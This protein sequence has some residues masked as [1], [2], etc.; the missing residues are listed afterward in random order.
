MS[1]TPTQWGASPTEWEHFTRL[2]LTA[3]LL[4]VVSNP[5][6]VIAG[7]SSLRA[8]GKTPSMYNRA[9]EAVGIPK[10]TTHSSTDRDVKR[11]QANG[12]LGI[13]LQT[14]TVRAIDV[15][16]DDPETADAVAWW[17]ETVLGHELPA[18]CRGDSRKFLLA[19]NMPGEFVK[20]VIHTA[21]GAIEF[22]ATGQQ[23]I[24]CGTHPKGQRY[25]WRGGLPSEIPSVTPAQFEELWSLLAKEFAI[26]PVVTGRG[27]SKRPLLP[28]NSDDIKDP[29]VSFL[30]Q[31]GWVKG[32]QRDGRVD[33]RC[34]WES[35]HT[36][37]SADSATTWFPAGVGGFEQG[38]FRCLHAHCEHRSD[39]EFLEEVGYIADAFE[40]VVTGSAAVDGTPA[41]GEE[42]PMPIFQRSRNGTI[43]STVHN[44][45][46]AAAREDVLGCH[47]AYDHFKGQLVVAE[48]VADLGTAQWRAM[49]DT[50]FTSMRATLERRG[51]ESVGRELIRDVV[52]LVA[53]ERSIDTAVEWLTRRVPEW[54]GVPRINGFWHTY[55]NAPRNDYTE[56]VS[57]YT[58][59]AL[60]GRVLQPGCKVDMVPVLIA[61]EGTGKTSGVAAI[62]PSEEFFAQ[63]RFDAKPDDLARAMRGTLLGELA[64]LRGLHTKEREAILDWITRT[65]EKWT[66][67]FKE[68]EVTFP[69]RLLMIG[70]T[71]E[72]E[73]LDDT[74]AEDR[75]WLPLKVGMTD[76]AALERDREQLWAEAREAFKLSGVGWQDAYRLARDVR[77]DHRLQ[78]PWA[79]RVQAWLSV[80]DEMDAS[81]GAVIRAL[82][83]VTSAEL[84]ENAL[85]M[86]TA[87]CSRLDQVRLGRVMRSLG[88]ERKNARVGGVVAKAYVLADSARDSL[89]KGVVDDLA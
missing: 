82:Q 81:K 29:V 88:Y 54:D 12:D 71:N 72:T 31:T 53:K 32:W 78:D 43:I 38:H 70:T 20:R 21:H 51:F 40:V 23:F 47:V 73:F 3:D 8:L 1:Q 45:M 74:G 79:E 41:E 61:G 44:V 22:L 18:R 75:R 77:K 50:D 10:W 26:E 48:P 30:E 63:L 39:Q 76:M 9:G 5:K 27:L 68:F 64:E 55:F 25:E 49:D 89:R 80:A 60:A 2:G 42:R 84:F 58:W 37:E 13:C 69:R 87:A 56:A 19:L 46:L 67:K 11:W 6:A 66:P 17:V 33:V 52:H 65:H 24:A 35:D 59:T 15:D 7:N 57:R 36:T 85:N 62:V 16:I 28:R 83:P 34:P 14:R 86:R 4:P